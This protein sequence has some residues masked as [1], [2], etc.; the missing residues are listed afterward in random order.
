LAIAFAPSLFSS[1]SIFLTSYEE[2]L[3]LD[4]RSALLWGNKI[5]RNL[6][7]I[8]SIMY[9]LFRQG[10][11]LSQSGFSLSKTDFPNSILLT[12]FAYLGLGLSWIV[13]YY[14]HYFATGHI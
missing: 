8:A 7:A 2:R 10:L 4:P 1:I 5:T 12:V 6:A 14:I 11:K 3:I 9:V 13:I